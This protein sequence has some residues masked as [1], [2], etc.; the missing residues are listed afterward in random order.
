[1]DHFA[2]NRTGFPREQFVRVRLPSSKVAAPCR[3]LPHTL[4][5]APSRVEVS[6][7]AERAVRRTTPRRFFYFTSQPITNAPPRAP[8]LSAIATSFVSSAFLPASSISSRWSNTK[9]CRDGRG[10]RQRR[11]AFDLRKGQRQGRHYHAQRW[12]H[13]GP[14]DGSETRQRR[15]LARGPLKAGELRLASLGWRAWA[16]ELGLAS[17]ENRYLSPSE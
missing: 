5:G 13:R 17:S 3:L 16:G 12:H 9:T 10:R 11:R 4:S 1:V 2:V 15:N 6:A 7:L 14:L 8:S